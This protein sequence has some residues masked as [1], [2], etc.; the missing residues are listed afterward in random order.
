MLDSYMVGRW[1]S[2]RGKDRG[3]FFWSDGWMLGQGQ[4]QGK[5]F[6]VGRRTDGSFY[7]ALEPPQAVPIPSPCKKI[8]LATVLKQ[9]LDLSCSYFCVLKETYQFFSIAHMRL[10]GH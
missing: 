8:S 6:L 5:F 1:R 2:D 4:S 10:I 9:V 3:S 7:F